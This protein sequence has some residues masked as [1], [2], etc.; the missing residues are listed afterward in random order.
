MPIGMMRIKSVVIV[1]HRFVYSPAD[2]LKKY[3]VR[4]S[5]DVMYIA[6]AF[7]DA[8]DRKSSFEVYE[9]GRL[10]NAGHTRDW[11]GLPDVLVYVKDVLYT[12]LWV[13]FS[14]KRWDLYVGADGLC[15]LVG[16]LC[17]RLKKVRKVVLWS[18]D[19]V[20]YGR[21]KWR[22][23]NWLYHKINKLALTYS[24]QVWNLSPRMENARR[25]FYGQRAAR[26]FAKQVVVPLG[27]W[28]E[29]K[30]L[31]DLAEVDK[32]TIVF[33]GHLLE[34][35]G[36]QLVL[37]AVPL[38]VKRI[39]DFK[40]LIIGTGNYEQ[41]LKKKARELGVDPYVKFLGKIESDEEVDDILSHCAC[42]VAPYDRSKDKWTAF[43]DPGKLK[44]YLSCGL[45][46]VL[47]DVPWNAYEIEYRRCGMVVR[48]NVE[49]LAE[50]IVK[51]L[52]NRPLLEEFRKN[53]FEYSREFDWNDIF[54]KAI[55]HVFHAPTGAKCI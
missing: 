10:L 13:F 43:A 50:A 38:I 1:T 23:A 27:V 17:R 14:K 28:T 22:L 33:L 52:S 42:A 9:A 11:K 24:D 48:Y 44:R 47:T 20:P 26:R 21:F 25:E 2:D 35:Q 34:K 54:E 32:H 19:F 40:F 53:A 5:V 8:P 4:K 16:V 49:E 30:R 39:P 46:V 3:L 41:D 18:I 37:Q 51:L 31:R 6:H 36:V 12:F 45:P 7:S 55:L 29:G 15:A